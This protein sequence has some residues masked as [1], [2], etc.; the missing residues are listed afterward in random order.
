MSISIVG[1]PTFSTTQASTTLT[2]TL[3]SGIA[4]G[5]Y[6]LLMVSCGEDSPVPSVTTPPSGYTALGTLAGFDYGAAGIYTHFYYKL[7]GASNPNPT[8]TWNTGNSNGGGLHAL[9][10]AYRTTG[11]WHSTTPISLLVAGNSEPSSMALPQ[12]PSFNTGSNNVHVVH[13][14]QTSD[15]NTHTLGTANSFTLRGGGN[16]IEGSD[17]SIYVA[18]RFVATQATIDHCIWSIDKGPDYCSWRTVGLKEQ[19]NESDTT[20]AGSTSASVVGSSATIKEAKL[21]SASST[22]ASTSESPA[23][24]TLYVHTHALYDDVSITEFPAQISQDFY[25]SASY[26]DATAVEFPVIT[27]VLVTIKP[28]PDTVTTAESPANIVQDYV[29]VSG[30][31][32]VTFVEYPAATSLSVTISPIPDTVSAISYP[33][34]IQQDFTIDVI[35]ETVA[36]SEFPG[37]ISIGFIIFSGNSSMSVSESPATIQIVTA[38]NPIF[39]VYCIN[40]NIGLT[41]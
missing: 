18:D 6:I 23:T 8:I 40:S 2:I 25:I 34:F 14:M 4:S 9:A 29:I 27:K 24:I 28:T 33:A 22:S 12:A 39:A 1:T 11:A 17:A 7:A 37:S 5:D 36:I 26:S 19:V 41:Y 10:V 38:F 20:N 3:P 21:I 16:S 35:P 13:F 32:T 31:T 15:D 30:S